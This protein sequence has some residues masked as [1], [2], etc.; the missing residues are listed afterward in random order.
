MKR[1]LLSLA[2][3]GM[4]AG[5]GAA[6]AATAEFQ[7][8]CTNSTVGGTLQTACTLTVARHPVGT[9][10]TD[11]GYWGI[12]STSWDLGDGNTATSLGTVYH[13]YV[14]VVGL[15]IN[16][17]VYCVDGSSASASHCLY[18]N[19]GVGGCIRPGA[20]WTP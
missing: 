18:N 6:S 19:F 20:G 1:H 15:T 13:T 16:V 17:T 5:T 8:Y 2:I 9:P 7:G 11:C 4:L 12:S 10:A 14:G 3:L